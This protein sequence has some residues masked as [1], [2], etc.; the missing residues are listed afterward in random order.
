MGNSCG[1]TRLRALGSRFN[2][3]IIAGSTCVTKRAAGSFATKF[4]TKTGS[5]TVVFG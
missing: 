4:K 1:G 2:A 5:H 3:D